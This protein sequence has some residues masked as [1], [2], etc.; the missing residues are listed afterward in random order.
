MPESSDWF[1]YHPA[2]GQKLTPHE[3]SM[4][5]ER[6]AEYESILA[7]IKYLENQKNLPEKEHILGYN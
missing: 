2:L 6:I 5:D 7:K 3:Q 4:F 1:S